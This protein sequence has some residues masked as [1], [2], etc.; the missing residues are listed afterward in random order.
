MGG[1]LITGDQVSLGS[2]NT[3]VDILGGGGGCAGV[4]GVMEALFRR[5]AETVV[6]RTKL[7]RGPSGVELMTQAAILL[8]IHYQA[9]LDPGRGFG[10]IGSRRQRGWS[11]SRVP[12]WGGGDAWL[13]CRG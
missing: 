1:M 7:A 11:L 12:G 8:F 6:G 5:Q 2:D 4:V 13:G 10:A 3:L 9:A